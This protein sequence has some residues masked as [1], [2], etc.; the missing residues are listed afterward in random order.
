MPLPLQLWATWVPHEF[1][2]TPY[3]F[4]LGVQRGTEVATYPLGLP[5]LMAAAMRVGGELGAYLVPPLGAGLLVW[6][7]YPLASWLAGPWAGLLASVLLALSPATLGL[8]VQPM[9]DV[10]AAA[11]W[12][13]AW[14]MS[15]RPGLGASAAAGAAVAA[16]TM[17]RPN[18]APLALILIPLVARDWDDSGPHVGTRW[19]RVLLFIGVAAIGPIVL[20]W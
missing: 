6:C 13:L 11:F 14:V 3:G 4:R 9:S 7:A 15:L 12:A 2:F 20:G 18:L 10:P 16:A 5:V 1:A 17:V 19:R 8:A